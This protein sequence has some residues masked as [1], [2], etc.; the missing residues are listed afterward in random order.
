MKK[1]A[2][3]LNRE[4]STE[5]VQI[6]NKYMKKCSSSLVIKE[7][8]IKTTLRFHL[9]PVRMAKTTTNAGKDAEK[10][11]HPYTVSENA[12]YY[13]QLVRMQITTTIMKSSMKIPQKAKETTAICQ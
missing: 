5:E 3:E 9:T 11:E 10:Q 6:A 1:W 12:N 4:F 13:N 2:H 7:I 8:Q